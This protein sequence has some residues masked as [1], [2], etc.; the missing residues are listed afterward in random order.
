MIKEA[1][2]DLLHYEI[3][4]AP[5]GAPWLVFVHG[6]GGSIRTWQFQVEHFAKDFRLLLLDLRDHGYSKDITPVYDAYD[7]DIVSNDIL[8]VFV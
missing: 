1:N 3:K 6:A 4:G 7:F 8:H 5:E 2:N